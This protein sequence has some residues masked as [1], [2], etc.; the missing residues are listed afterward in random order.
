MGPR[1][2]AAPRE[3]WGQPPST[4]R[5]LHQLLPVV[6]AHGLTFDP[7]T[8]DIVF[9]SGNEVDQLDQLDPRSGTAV[10][11]FTDANTS[12]EFGQS[13]VD[14]NGHLFVAS[15]N[16]NLLGIDYD[17]TKLIGTST[18][19]ES[20]LVANLDDNAPLSGSRALST[21]E[22]GSLVLLATRPLRVRPAGPRRNHV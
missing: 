2:T 3:L 11:T 8:N 1:P 19:A 15:N 6:P 21:P 13:A 7:L 9:S 14:G 5:R 17:C 18:S 22:R 12:D 10:S 4:K 20:F 16:G